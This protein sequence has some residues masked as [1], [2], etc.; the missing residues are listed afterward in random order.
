MTAVQFPIA[1]AAAPTP[2]STR[3]RLSGVLHVEIG[4]RR[5]DEALR[6]AKGRLLLAYL[7]IGRGRAF[8][9]DELID[10]LWPHEA[11][12]DPDAAFSTV[13]T[14]TRQAL[15]ADV[16]LGRAELTIQLPAAA[17]VDWEA[18]HQSVESADRRLDAG[19]AAGAL[20]LAREAAEI[21]RQPFLPGACGPWVE[22]RRR[23]A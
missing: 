20:Q 6:G 3:I 11:P 2:A 1:R 8:T 5:A 4:G 15:G 23:T 22:E 13:L 10:A 18:M 7:V 9:R 19:D 12:N 17:W 14:R 16:I 21:A